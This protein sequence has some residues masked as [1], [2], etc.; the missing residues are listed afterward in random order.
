MA[1]I[2]SFAAES[3]EKTGKGAARA[4]RRN[5]TI[6]GII[7]GETKKPEAIALHPK[8]LER[9][10]HRSGFFARLFDIELGGK[11]HRVIAR[12]I[13]LDP[14]TERV[15]HVDFMRVGA[16]S[17][18]HVEVP[19]HFIGQD[20]SPG[21]RRGGVLNIVTHEIELICNANAI[22]SEIVVDLTGRE[23]NTSIHISSLTLPSGVQVA[24][25]NQDFTVA[26]IVPPTVE[27]ATDEAA[28]AT[29][30]AGAATPAS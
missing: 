27:K 19:V 4:A 5:G 11:K 21:L 8:L 17:K 22:P 12:D 25:A 3:R 28:A 30:A 9:E 15:L 6:P 14:V 23:I 13:Q 2:T 10:I 1:D 20:K 26:T 7:Y 16:N 24:H 29:P 18:I